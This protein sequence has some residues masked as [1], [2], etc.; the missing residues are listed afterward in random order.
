MT[1]GRSE[2]ATRP[3]PTPRRPPPTAGSFAL[4]VKGM[5]KVPFR[6][7]A[8]FATSKVAGGTSPAQMTLP[9]TTRTGSGDGC[10]RTSNRR[11]RVSD[12]L[13][14][15]APERRPS[16]PWPQRRTA[17]SGAIHGPG[18]RSRRAR[19]RGLNGRHTPN[20][21]F[22][23][24]KHFELIDYRCARSVSRPRGLL[25]RLTSDAGARHLN[26]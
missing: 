11:S 7:H 1:S 2:T 16:P 14:N 25:S 19:Q 20:P 24:D 18:C 22:W 23:R 5:A 6:A 10:Q 12:R 17:L 21:L 8:T 9:E 3:W 26:G 13:Q 4:R 15:D